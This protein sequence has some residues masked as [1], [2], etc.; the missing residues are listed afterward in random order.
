MGGGARARNDDG[1]RAQGVARTCGLQRVAETIQGVKCRCGDA[2]DVARTRSNAW[3]R[4]RLTDIAH[5][6]RLPQT[7]TPRVTQPSPDEIAGRR[8]F[9]PTLSHLST[10]GQLRKFFSTILHDDTDSRTPE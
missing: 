4:W 2:S 3:S 5:Y 6:S 10:S 1:R 7:E 8:A 9:L